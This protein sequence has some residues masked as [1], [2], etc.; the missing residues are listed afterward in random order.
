MKQKIE[1][2]LRS[3]GITVSNVLVLG[4]FVHVD[5]FASYNNQ[6]QHIFTAAGFRIRKAQ[7]GVHLD[8]YRGYRMSAEL[9]R[10]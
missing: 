10:I 7:E 2:L 9:V 6:L 4:R 3:A 5:S 8:G 1:Y